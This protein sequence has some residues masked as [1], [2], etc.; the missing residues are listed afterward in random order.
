MMEQV[1]APNL[2]M[3]TKMKTCPMAPDSPSSS[4]TGPVERT[5]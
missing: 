5:I 4:S 2:E 1:S 3:V